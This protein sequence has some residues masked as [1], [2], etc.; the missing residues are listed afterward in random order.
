MRFFEWLSFK[1]K[2]LQKPVRSGTW[3]L[4][5]HCKYEGFVYGTPYSGGHEGTGVSAPWCPRCGLNDQLV[6]V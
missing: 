6:R 5:K 3:A 2:I 4:C 1:P